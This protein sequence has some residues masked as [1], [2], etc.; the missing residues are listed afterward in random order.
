MRFRWS[1]PAMSSPPRS[2]KVSMK[3]G[4]AALATGECRSSA[5]IRGIRLLRRY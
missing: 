3:L 5:G 1:S 2:M 4:E